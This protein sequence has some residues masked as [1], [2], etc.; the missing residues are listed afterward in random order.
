MWASSLAVV[1]YQAARRRDGQRA[2]AALALSCA[3]HPDQDIASMTQADALKDG[4]RQYT[5][6]GGD[7]HGESA[8]EGDA[9]RARYSAGTADLRSDG[10]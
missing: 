1:V 3:E 7:G 2:M 5:D 4:A 10:A 9:S 8:P 6:A